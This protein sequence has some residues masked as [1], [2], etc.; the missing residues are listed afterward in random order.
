[1]F[2]NI[3]NDSSGNNMYNYLNNNIYMNKTLNKKIIFDKNNL[4][5]KKY[6]NNTQKNNNDFICQ[7]IIRKK[8]NQLFNIS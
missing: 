8:I 1:M 7:K 3:K 2:H 6:F 4:H 5:K